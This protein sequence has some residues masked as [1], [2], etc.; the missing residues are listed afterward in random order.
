MTLKTVTL[1]DIDA[2]ALG[3]GILGTGGGGNPYLGSLHLREVIRKHGPARVIDPFDL[4]DDAMVVMA[5][6]IGAPTASIEKIEQGEELLT[7]LRAFEQHMGRKAAAIGIAEIGGSNSF[8]PVV[9]A[10]Q[11]GVPVVDCD[12]MGRAFP[13]LPMSVFFFE[14]EL[15]VTPLAM[16]D[17]GGNRVIIPRTADAK[18]AERLARTL[19]TR[20]GG[21]AGLI[22]SF[23]P[24]SA[25]K[26][27][28]VHYTLSLARDLGRRV[29]TADIDD[30]PGAIAEALQGKVIL[31]GKIVDLERRTTRGFARGTLTIEGFSGREQLYIEFQ[32][33]FLIA[34]LNGEVVA[35]VPD[36]ISI[37]TED[38]GEPVSTEVLR[39]GMRVAVLGIPA[40]RGLKTPKGLA[41]VG[42]R[43]FGYDVDFNPMPGGIIGLR[44]DGL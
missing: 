31:R 15:P 32:N 18:W 17:A 35:T 20:M 12:A 13:E 9:L 36:L 11:A 21:T 38:T 25:I 2:I 5:G 16:V 19:A 33:E 39:Y 30:A 37:V 1:D 44:P 10:I 8:A 26:T 41:V 14:A 27:Y 40:A 7:A 3:A 34:Q 42:P 4:D 29:M 43:A 6:F 28:G 23:V 22:A 24:G